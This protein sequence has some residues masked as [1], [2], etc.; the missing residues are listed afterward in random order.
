MVVDYSNKIQIPSASLSTTSR[1]EKQGGK[2][3][4]KTVSS[5]KL[6]AKNV[7]RWVFDDSLHSIRR[8][9]CDSRVTSVTLTVLLAIYRPFIL[10]LST[11]I[12]FQSH[13][14]AKES[15]PTF[16]GSCCAS[17][18]IKVRRFM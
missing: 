18:T 1:R 5:A 4:S 12:S 15:R 6:R 9:W 2:Q 14:L 7:A 11:L 3:F 16:D 17:K 8:K 13:P 10:I